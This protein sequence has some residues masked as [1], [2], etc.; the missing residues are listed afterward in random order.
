MEI[1]K[2]EEMSQY[3]T[4]DKVKDLGGLFIMVGLGYLLTTILFMV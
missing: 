3:T 4:L 1:K 2:L